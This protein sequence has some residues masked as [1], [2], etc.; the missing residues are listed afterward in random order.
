MIG[1]DSQTRVLLREFDWLLQIGELRHDQTIYIL[2]K[3][4]T[5]FFYVND[6]KE[7][8]VHQR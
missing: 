7:E 6:G 5:T 3:F 4:A 2:T 8:G 1:K